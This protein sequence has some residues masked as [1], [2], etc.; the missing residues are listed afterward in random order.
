MSNHSHLS[1]VTCPYCDHEDHDGW[2]AFDYGACDGDS[3]NKHC[4]SC[5]K[6]FAVTV[7][8]DPKFSTEQLPN[9]EEEP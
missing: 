4:K 5:D 3:V 2:E 6:E 7:H 1:L 8:L 9:Q